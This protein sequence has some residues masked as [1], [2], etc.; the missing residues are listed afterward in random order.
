MK[1]KKFISIILITLIVTLC[2][3]NFCRSIWH[4]IYIKI[5]GGRT[6]AEVISEIEIKKPYLKD[7]SHGKLTIVIIKDDKTLFLLNDD[8]LLFTFPV[9][10]ASGNLGPKIKRGDNQVPEGVY[11]ISALNPNSAYYL[12]AKISYPNSD[13][14]KRS[15]KLKVEDMGDDIF[16][17]GKSASVGCVAVGDENIED[18]FYLL[19]RLNINNIKVIITPV[20][21]RIKNLPFNVSH[22]HVYDKIKLEL[23]RLNLKSARQGDAPEPATLTR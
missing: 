12:S 23:L 21:F 1:F 11:H 10:A 22:D 9:L 2:V 18:I 15:K 5:M 3:F 17:H 6:I 4:P 7:I 16:I 20:D 14:Y 8:K 13:D 19:S